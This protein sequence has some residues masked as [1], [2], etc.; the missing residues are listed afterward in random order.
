MPTFELSSRNVI[1]RGNSDQLR[2]HAVDLLIALL[3]FCQ[4]LT[5]NVVW[6]NDL[7]CLVAGDTESLEKNISLMS[8]TIN[9]SDSSG[10]HSEFGNVRWWPDPFFLPHAKGLVLRLLVL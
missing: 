2:Y 8:F 4:T 3:D 1:M 10:Q 5:G 9:A 6:H 7:P